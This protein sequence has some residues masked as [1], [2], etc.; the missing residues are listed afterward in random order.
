MVAT[1][2][3]QIL[4]ATNSEL[5]DIMKV[6]LELNNVWIYPFQRRSSLRSVKSYVESGDVGKTMVMSSVEALHIS[7]RALNLKDCFNAD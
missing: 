5:P 6:K 2:G 7:L 3:K 1:A 4:D